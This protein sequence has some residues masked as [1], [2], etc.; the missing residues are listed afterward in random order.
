MYV[1]TAQNYYQCSDSS[2]TLV[3]SENDTTRG[4]TFQ[5]DNQAFIDALASYHSTWGNWSLPAAAQPF[6]TILPTALRDPTYTHLE[7]GEAQ[8]LAV[9]T[10]LGQLG[11]VESHILSQTRPVRILD[12]PAITTGGVTVLPIAA[13]LGMPGA[14]AFE[15]GAAGLAQFEALRLAAG[16]ADFGD[17][18]GFTIFAPAGDGQGNGQF[19]KE[20]QARY[21]S[22]QQLKSLFNNHVSGLVEMEYWSQ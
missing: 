22:I 13:V 4:Y 1:H 19:F 10:T 3:S 12:V 18:G 6:H 11:D 9:Q 16:E 5:E 21:P 8:V 17:F 20:A 2:V 15:Q 14:Y 7:N